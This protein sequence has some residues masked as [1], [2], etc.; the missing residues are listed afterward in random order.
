MQN[1]A[2]HDFGLNW[3]ENGRGQFFFKNSHHIW[4]QHLSFGE[5]ANFYV[6]QR[7]FD[8]LIDNIRF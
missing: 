6:K 3:T 4:N 2:K 5:I 1:K 7:K 8:F